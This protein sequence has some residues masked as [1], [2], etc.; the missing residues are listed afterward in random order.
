MT[1][2]LQHPVTIGHMRFPCITACDVLSRLFIIWSLR[3]GSRFSLMQ[4]CVSMVEA[5]SPELAASHSFMRS[6]ATFEAWHWLGS[7]V[8][9]IVVAIVSFR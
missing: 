5:C 4:D 9:N 1:V 3:R 2:G 8:S 6:E 7:H